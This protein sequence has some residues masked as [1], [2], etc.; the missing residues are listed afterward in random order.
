[1]TDTI[2]HPA[3]AP[4]GHL[5]PDTIDRLGSLLSAE[6]TAQAEIVVEQ[7]ER[8]RSLPE[9]IDAH[10]LEEREL[11]ERLADRARATLAEIDDAFSRMA[12][13]TYGSCRSCGDPVPIERLEAI[14]HAGACV[15]CPDEHRSVFG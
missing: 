10:G 6:R 3:S 1:M 11:A 2:V 14:P 13:G 4:S 9:Q 8:I 7:E 15:V 5:D 12:A